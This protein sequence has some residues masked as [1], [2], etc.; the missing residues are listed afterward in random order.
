MQRRALLLAAVAA[1]AVLAV[2]P[3]AAGAAP[4]VTGEATNFQLNAAHN[5]VATGTALPATMT[6]RW[7]KTFS[8]RPLE[9]PVIAGG[10]VFVTVEG[11]QN[12]A[13]LH[14]LDARTGAQAWRPVDLPTAWGRALLAYDAGRLF[15]LTSDADLH[16][17]DAGTGRRLWSRPRL[18]GEALSAPPAAAGGRVFVS[19][20]GSTRYLFAVDGA[21]GRTLWSSAADWGSD[22][23]P[24]V[25]GRGVY[26]AGAC[27][28]VYR[29]DV[30]DGRRIWKHDSGCSGGGGSV[31][32][33]AGGELFVRERA[34][35]TDERPAVL[36]ATTGARLRGFASVLP[37]TVV[38]TGMLTVADGRLAA[39]PVAG[40]AAKWRTA[41]GLGITTPAVVSGRVAY[42]GTASGTV[43]GFDI[44]T[45][46]QVWSG[47]A[48]SPIAGMSDLTSRLYTSLAVGSGVLAVPAT[49]RLTVFS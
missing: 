19:T 33:W 22:S 39:V 28:L 29:F 2:V 15:V 40:G 9:Y 5:G 24:A 44:G 10:K 41:A 21:T 11:R 46:R 14:A 23:A 3:G 20:S 43:R 34:V 35:G 42:V 1:S 17:F 38:G 25:Y 31:P 36:S 12:V 48:G 49:N 18:S 6:R 47:A 7:T 16:A 4:A 26:L 8:G 32:V 45:G 30:T 37:P 13:T 27:R